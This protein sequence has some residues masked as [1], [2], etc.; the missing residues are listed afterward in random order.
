MSDSHQTKHCLNC[1]ATLIGLHCHQCGQKALVSRF[2]LKSIF[3]DIPHS[4]FHVDRGIFPTIIGLILRPGQT[5]NGYLDG[6]RVRFFNPLTFLALAAGVQA[7]LFGNKF[8]IEML[9]KV[10]VVKDQVFLHTALPSLARWLSL[11]L[12]VFVPLGALGT[13]LVFRKEKRNYAEHLV[14]QTY[15]QAIGIVLMTVPLYP[16]L[17]VAHWRNVTLLPATALIGIVATLALIT[18]HQTIVLTALFRKPGT[19]LRTFQRANLASI[20]PVV[21][22]AAGWLL[23]LKMNAIPFK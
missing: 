16:L 14:I 11:I 12:V 15:I 6:Q 8:T 9:N 17:L 1:G 5:I 7:F 18:Q 22:A 23:T 10:L 19:T 2:A 4:L 3:H 13:W 20:V 21:F